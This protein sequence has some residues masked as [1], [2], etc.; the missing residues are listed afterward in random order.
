MKKR[1]L[2]RADGNK[3]TGLGHLY[4]LFAIVE[5]LKEDFEY[6][7]LTRTSS[8][9][10][11]IPVEYDLKLIDV[12]ISIEQEPDWLA[13]QF[14]PEESILIADGYHFDSSYQ[15]RIKEL[16]FT[17]VYIDDL[18][19]ECMHADLVI[20]HSPSI[21]TDSFNDSGHTDYALGTKYALLRP[22]FL[23]AAKEPRK[24][25]RI[26]KAFVCFGGADKLDLSLKT[27]KALLQIDQI[28]EIHVVL[29]AAYKNNGIHELVEK[30]SSKIKLHS[31]LSEEQL[32]NLMKS[33]NFAVAPSSTICYEL[34]CVKMP[35]LSGYFVENQ[36]RIYDDLVKNK[37]ISLGGNFTNFTISDFKKQIEKSIKDRSFKKNLEMQQKLFDGKTGLRVLSI[38]NHL[39]ISFRK[40]NSDDLIMVYN[41]SNDALVRQNSYESEPIKIEDHTKWFLDRIANK[42]TLFLIAMVNNNPAGIVRYEIKEKETVIGILINKKYRG[43]KLAESFLYESAKLYFET[44]N[45]PVFAYIKE[46]NIA[47]I[48]SFENARYKYDRTEEVKGFKSLLYKLEQRDVRK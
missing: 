13:K 1:I 34:C 14:K 3:T 30:N 42:N 47:S 11:V 12:N 4:R 31:N 18:A 36:K 48:K 22:S 33:C 28:L 27:T 45:N 7:Y 43:Q 5:M 15:K 24:I 6:T 16:G 39:A 23:T 41:W 2:F 37:V 17:M 38:V 21:S 19:T 25:D 8:T 10:E 35:I 9:I 32:V 40:A 26:D 46:E 44:S 29:G 20:N